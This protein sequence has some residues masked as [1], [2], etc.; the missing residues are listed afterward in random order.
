MDIEDLQIITS[1]HKQKPELTEEQTLFLKDILIKNEFDNTFNLIKDIQRIH[2]FTVSKIDLIKIYNSLDEQY[3]IYDLK[4]KIIKKIQKSQSGII[5][6]TV[7]T[8]GNPWRFNKD[9]EKETINYS[10]KNDCYYCPN[11]KP[12]KDNNW[13]QQARSYLY[14][15]PSILRSNSCGF[16]PIKQMNSRLSTLEKMGHTID[17]LEVLVL[18]GTWSSYPK[19]YQEEFVTH[20]Y[21]AANTYYDKRE[22]ILSLEEEIELNEKAKVHIIGLTLETRSDSININEIKNFRRYNCTRIQIGI[23]HTDNAVLKMNNRGE[24]IEK[25]KKAIKMLK[26]NNFKIDGHLMLNLY[27]STVDKDRIMLN[28]ILTDPD[29]QVDQ[30]KIYPCAIVPFTKIK[31]LYEA[32]IY[33]PYDDCHL[34]DL[35][36]E[37]KMKITKQF[38]INRIIRDIS[39]HYIIDGYSQQFASIRQKLQEDMKINNWSCKCIRCREVKGNKI[40]DE[41]T[42]LEIMEYEASGGM[43]YYISFENGEYLIGFIRLRLNRNKELPILPILEDAALIRELHVYSALSNVGE[44]D[45]H[46][47]QHKGYGR[48]L[49]EKAEEIAISNGF[50]K[51]AIIAGT[52]VRNYYRKFG[53]ELKETYMI[54]ELIAS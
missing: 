7:V 30:L 18:G 31:E 4:K 5:S 25:V 29:L 6:I 15:E 21:Y 37:F 2:K 20:L 44:N 48:R 49:I 28:E 51:I 46:S 13:T 26:I 16:D 23:Q 11:E 17:K 54:K 38:R 27:G 9:G 14:T 12:S 32:G 36:K 24:S 19:E 10:C 50:K 35:I 47:L 41:N 33:K 40:D 8:S 45:D 42:K 1:G 43:E 39:G 3:K 52:G 22:T 53:Y 34:Y